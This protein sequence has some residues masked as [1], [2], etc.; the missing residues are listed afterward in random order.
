MTDREMRRHW[1]TFCTD[2]LA[3]VKEETLGNTWGAVPPP[4]DAVA[5][6]QAEVDVET[7]GDTLSDTTHW[8]RRWLKR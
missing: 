4:V 7:L 1:S 6:S 8:S 3:E 5:A 2:T